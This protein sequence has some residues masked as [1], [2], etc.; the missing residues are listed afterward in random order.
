MTQESN[1]KS[2]LAPHLQ[3][4]LQ[5]KR[6][7]LLKEIVEAEGYPDTGVF[8]EI[9]FGTE[10]TGCVPLTEFFDPAFKPALMTRD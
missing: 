1:F 6:L 8:D 10:L 3:H 9:S 2:S 4:I 7:L 5:P